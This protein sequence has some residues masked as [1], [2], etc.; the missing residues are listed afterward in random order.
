MFY[1]LFPYQSWFKNN[2]KLTQGFNFLQKLLDSKVIFVVDGSFFPKWSSLISAV[3]YASI[4][5]KIVARGD[6]I[7]LVEEEYCYLYAAELCRALSVMNGIDFVLSLF[8]YLSKAFYLK[9]GS[10]CQ[11][12]LHSL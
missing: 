5:Y 2:M 4:N 9:I 11:L 12:V 1:E 10:D 3:W 7:S 8:P 6:F